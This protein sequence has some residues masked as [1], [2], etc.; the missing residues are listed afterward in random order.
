MLESVDVIYNTYIIYCIYI[1]I[2]NICI[3]ISVMRREKECKSKGDC[4]YQ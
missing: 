3:F 2:Y 4:S 1:I